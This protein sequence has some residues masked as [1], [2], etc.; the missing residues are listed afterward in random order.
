MPTAE[1]RY[2]F[3]IQVGQHMHDFRVV[4]HEERLENEAGMPG[5]LLSARLAAFEVNPPGPIVDYK[6]I[7]YAGPSRW[8]LLV[9]DQPRPNLRTE[10]VWLRWLE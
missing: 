1:A 8:Y 3:R 10:R 6:R 2:D 5:K 9:N 4:M 7:A